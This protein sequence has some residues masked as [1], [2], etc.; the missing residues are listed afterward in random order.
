[1][2][3]DSYSSYTPASYALRELS[4]KVEM[5]DEHASWLNDFLDRVDQTYLWMLKC[6]LKE[7]VF[8]EDDNSN[9]QSTDSNQN[10]DTGNNDSRSRTATSFKNRRRSA[11]D[12]YQYNARKIVTPGAFFVGNEVYVVR[13]RRD[14]AGSYAMK[15]VSTPN[16]FALEY[17]GRG[18]EQTLSE[19]D[20][21]SEKDALPY[22]RLK[23]IK[24]NKDA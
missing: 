13:L 7:G 20:R 19:D 2:T 3:D 14:R 18:F 9:E 22:M 4:E 16:G 8:V 21:M 10:T 15:V 6:P 24:S 1:M 5:S 12:R 23:V 17:A 11:R